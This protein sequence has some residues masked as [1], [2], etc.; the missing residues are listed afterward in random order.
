LVNDKFWEVRA[1]S[2]IDTKTD[3]SGTRLKHLNATGK[4]TTEAQEILLKEKKR[5]PE[6]IYSILDTNFPE[7]IH[8]DIIDA[9]GFREYGLS[10]RRTIPRDSSFREKILMAYEYKCAVCGL[11]AR[12]GD[13][14][15][16]LEAAH[17]KWHH[18]GGPDVVS[19]GMAL[20]SLHHKLYDR[21]AFAISKDHRLAASAKIHNGKQLE[22]VLLRYQGKK[23]NLPLN[24]LEIPNQE[25]LDWN[26]KNIFKT[27]AR[28]FE[29]NE[30]FEKEAAEP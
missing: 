9:I 16:A 20:C 24:P 1:N 8:Q 27:P 19:N 4:F 21:G 26:W 5:I 23:I 15:V 13:S 10:V 6:L 11:G 22:E 17:I 30:M 12:L 7:T 3:Y 18:A 28:Y 2:L 14:L 25:F 29:G